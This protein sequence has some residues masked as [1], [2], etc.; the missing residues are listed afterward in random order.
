M[1]GRF[2]ASNVADEEREIFDGVEAAE[3]TDADGGALED[4]DAREIGGIDGV[5]D[6]VDAA[7]R[8]GAAIDGDLFDGAGGGRRPRRQLVEPCAEPTNASADGTAP[9]GSIG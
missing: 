6:N 7:G 3:E 8:D 1:S 9:S 2:R 5:G 4:L